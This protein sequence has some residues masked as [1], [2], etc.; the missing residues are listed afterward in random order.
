[1]P[2]F[3]AM[4]SL[5]PVAFVIAVLPI[6]GRLVSH[7]SLALSTSRADPWSRRWWD[8]RGSWV[9]F[10]P[11]GRWIIGTILGFRILQSD[12]NSE[13][14][15]GHFIEEPHARLILVVGFALLLSLLAIVS[16]CS[17]SSNSVAHIFLGDERPFCSQYI[18]RTKSFGN[19]HIASAKK[20]LSWKV[21]VYT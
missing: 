14:Y 18:P 11:F 21:F 1:M 3:L 7:L 15:P 5:T 13:V 19:V 10:G 17:P 6:F 16:R 12:R 20:K 9:V 8:W 2:K 4:V